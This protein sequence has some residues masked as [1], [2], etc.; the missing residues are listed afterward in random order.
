W[1]QH[2]NYLLSLGFAVGGVFLSAVLLA[3]GGFTWGKFET[4]I[5]LMVLA[6][7][8]V[9][10]FSGPRNATIAVT[11]AICI[12]GIP[13]IVVMARKPQRS[14]AKLWAGYTIANSL[15]LFGGA[16]W[17]VE[18]RLAPA[19]FVALSVAMLVACW[20]KREVKEQN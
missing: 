12:A 6:S 14:A 16:M 3:Q 8:A 10:K 18:E 4:V 2:G 20:W 17:S 7:L 1:Q 9:W 15:S 19:A 11:T 13:G 5:A